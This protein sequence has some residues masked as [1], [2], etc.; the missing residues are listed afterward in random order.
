MKSFEDPDLA[1]CVIEALVAAGH[2]ETSIVVPMLEPDDDDDLD[3]ESE[4]WRDR[5]VNNQT[6]PIKQLV[7]LVEQHRDLLPKLEELQYVLVNVAE[8]YEPD[9]FSLS[10]IEVCT[11]LE[12]VAIWSS[13]PKLDLTPLTALPKLASVDLE[14][15]GKLKNSARCSRSHRSARWSARTSTTEPR[16]SFA[17]ATST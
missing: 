17:S 14:C 8:E 9:L 12:R 3:D 2:V 6:E 16:P 5:V 11:G 4:S 1:L 10:G 15:A 13:D 7:A